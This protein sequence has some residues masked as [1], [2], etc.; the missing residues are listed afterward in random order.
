M[1]C[2]LAYVRVNVCVTRLCLDVCVGVWCV[3]VVCVSPCVRYAKA[4]ARV[5]VVYEKVSPNVG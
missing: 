2:V 1:V 3:A 4:G 5:Y